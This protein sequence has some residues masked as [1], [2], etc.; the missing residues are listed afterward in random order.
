[1][2]DVLKRRHGVLREKDFPEKLRLYLNMLL[3]WL[4]HLGAV[5]EIH[6]GT[7]E[8]TDLQTFPEFDDLI[9][10]VLSE[11]PA[12]IAAATLLVRARCVVMH[13]ASGSE[14]EYEPSSALLDQMR[15]AS[16]DASARLE[17]LRNWLQPFLERWPDAR[18]L[19]VLDL[20]G[21]GLELARYL[22]GMRG[23]GSA[24]ITVLDPDPSSAARLAHENDIPSYVEVLD[25]SRD[26]ETLQTGHFDLV[27]SS[28]RL[29]E[30]S[31]AGALL[32]R[33]VEASRS[34][35]VLA[36]IEP[37][38]SLLAEALYSLREGSLE[39]AIGEQFPTSNFRS[40]AE[41]RSA[42]NI[43]AGFDRVVAERAVVLGHPASLIHGCLAQTDIQ[44]D[45]LH[46][47]EKRQSAWVI[48]CGAAKA[49]REQA[50]AL[51]A[52]IAERGEPVEV[53]TAGRTVDVSAVS[54]MLAGLRS[55]KAFSE[56][57]QK[58]VISMPAP[59]KRG[60]ARVVSITR[61]CLNAISIAGAAAAHEFTLALVVPTGSGAGA[62]A[63]AGHAEQ[64]ALWA[65][66]RVLQNEFPDLTVRRLDVSPEQG[67]PELTDEALAAIA[68]HPGECEVISETSGTRK[69]RVVPGFRDRASKSP[70]AVALGFGRQGSLRTLAWHG[71][72]RQP[73]GADQV[74]IE[75]AATGLNFRDVMWS[76]G[77]LPEE[78]LED[79]Y[80]GPSLG[81]ECSGRVLRVGSDVDHLKVGDPVIAFTRDGFASHVTVPGHAV[82]KIGEDQDLVAA[83]TVPVAFLTAYY[84][85]VKLGNLRKDQ[86]LLIHGGAGGVG[87]A[88]LQSAKSVGARV[89]ATAGSD[90]KRNLLTTLG[91]DHVL[92][93]RSLAFAVDVLDLTDGKGVHVVLN[94]L[95]GEAME[96]SIELVRPFGRFLELGKRDFY[97][98]TRIGL[99]PF[100]KNVSYFGIDVDQLLTHDLSTAIKMIRKIFE[101]FR[102]GRFTHLPFRLFKGH[103][104]QDAFRFMQSSGHIGKILLA[105]PSPAQ[106][107]VAEEAAPLEFDAEGVHVVVGGLG[108]FGVEVARWLADHGARKIALTGRTG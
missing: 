50:D 94:S 48:I 69:V 6:P 87:L 100:R 70:A 18:P 64:S 20:A 24:M 60:E 40:A 104:V 103:A 34:N 54:R 44:T 61:Q 77:M 46:G 41:W 105:P 82:A 74:E 97:E 102:A 10:T 15:F 71:R 106:I 88:A 32:K 51:A 16:P 42:I 62:D 19:R 59:K 21:S 3:N 76:L 12:E 25:A 72:N 79:G 4:V 27:L 2:L 36:A 38:R 96:R 22:V 58:T 65:F 43:E 31:D 35:V 108:G 39:T 101:Q 67:L 57:V 95:A 47:D 17:L 9:K 107:P 73:P 78:A 52:R 68:D 30:F 98:G 56:A 89:I 75:V 28:G 8:F 63:G 55:T 23:R 14:G 86:W 81:L 53:F 83:A 5:T 11:C 90:E 91:A 84:A 33:V 13:A 66:A 93:S 45:G 29:H 7:Y 1:V 49:E 85:L 80:G 37:E 92:D 26:L 99:R